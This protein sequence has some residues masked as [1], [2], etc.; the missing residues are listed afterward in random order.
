MITS[1]KIL[2]LG[3][4]KHQASILSL[5]KQKRYYVILCDGDVN[6]S[7]KKYADKFYNISISNKYKILEIATE[8]KIS[9]IISYASDVGAITQCFVANKLK[10]PTNKIKSI[11]TLVY[12]NKFSQNKSYDSAQ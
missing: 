12:K 9:A 2:F 1:K 5:A 11:E 6:C 7:G 10:L 4:A 8:Q 3:G